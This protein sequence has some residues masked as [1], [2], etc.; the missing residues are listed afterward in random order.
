MLAESFGKEITD[1]SLVQI[2]ISLLK[3]S[4]N[5]VKLAA[6]ESLKLLLKNLGKEKINMLVKPVQGLAADLNSEIKGK[7]S[8]PT[9]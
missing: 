4:E 1:V 5:Q 9:P 7:T 3:D 6:I 2:F 8:C